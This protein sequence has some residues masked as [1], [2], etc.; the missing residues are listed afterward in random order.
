[1]HVVNTPVGFVV[2][3]SLLSFCFI[4][5]KQKA[6]TAITCAMKAGLDLLEAVAG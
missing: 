6:S 1:M 4:E 3:F 2:V 5:L